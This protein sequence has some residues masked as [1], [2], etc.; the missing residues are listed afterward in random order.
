MIEGVLCLLT[1]DFSIEDEHL[2]INYRFLISN[3]KNALLSIF[4]PLLRTNSLLPILK[5]TPQ[6][7]F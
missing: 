4:R 1:R 7:T 6:K 3:E 2:K 5:V